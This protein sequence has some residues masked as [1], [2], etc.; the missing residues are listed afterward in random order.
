MLSTIAYL[1]ELKVREYHTATCAGFLQ[2]LVTTNEKWERQKREG[3]LSSECTNEE[4]NEREGHMKGCCDF[5]YRHSLGY[6]S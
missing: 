2:A 6:S 4:E 3:S 1:D 5:K